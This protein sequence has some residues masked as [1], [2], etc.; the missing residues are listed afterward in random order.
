MTCFAQVT[1]RVSAPPPRCAVVGR[2]G[3]GVDNIAVDTATELGM[4]VTYV[5]TTASTRY[6]T[7]SWPYC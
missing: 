3:V 7:T 1:E 2:F 4:A 6:R 5:R